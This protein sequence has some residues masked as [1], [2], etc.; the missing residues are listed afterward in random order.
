MKNDLSHMVLTVLLS[1]FFMGT[2]AAQESKLSVK[3]VVE[4]KSGPLA[5]VNVY[6]KG[7]TNG[8]I[9]NSKGVAS[10]NQVKAEDTIVFSFVGYIQQEVV[11]GNR[12]TLEIILQQDDLTLEDVVV[13][14][15]GTQKKVNLTGAV[16][17]IDINESFLSKPLT[18][19]SSALAGLNA[20]VQANQTSGQPGSDNASIYI[21]GIGTLNNNAPLILIDGIEGPIDAI[22][23]ADI[24]SISFLKD[25]AASA[26]YGVRAGNGVVL[27]TTKQAE[28]NK[29]SVTYN[30]SIALTQPVNLIDL[31]SNYADYMEFFNEAQA[32]SGILVP[33]YNQETIDL[34]RE[35]SKSPNE[36]NELGVP[37]YV[38]YPNTDW[39]K[40]LF[41]NSYIQSHNISMT[42]GGDKTRMLLSANYV[43]NPGLVENTGVKRY[44]IRANAEA[45]VTKWLT[46]GT[47]TYASQDDYEMGNFSSANSYLIQT[48]PGVYPRWNGQYGAPE[49]SE[50]NPMSNNL[51]EKLNNTDGTKRSSR[52]NTTLFSKINFMSNLSWEFR[53]N[54]NRRFDE[55]HTWPQRGGAV[56][57]STGTVAREPMALADMSVNTYNFTNYSYTLENLL[58]YNVTIA[59]NHEIS[60]LAGY[61]EFYYQS[62]WLSTEKKGLA[63]EYATIPSGATTLISTEGS[64]N[65]NASRSWFG[66]LN[67][68]YKSRYLFEGN[69][70]YDGTSKFHPKYRWGLFPSA[71]VAWRITEE[72]FMKWSRKYLDNLKIRVSY[73]Q[74]GN[75]AASGDYD[76]QSNYAFTAGYSLNNVEQIAINAAKIA[77]IN[78]GWERTNMFNVGLDLAAFGNRLN[79]Q[80]DVYNRV[81]KGILYVPTL[82]P[83]M[84][85]KTSASMNLAN[86]QN[87]GVELT[88]GWKDHIKDFHYSISAN[89]AFNKNRVL[90]YQGSLKQGWVTDKD[91][92]RKWVSNLSDVSNGSTR[93]VLEGHEMYVYYLMPTYKGSGKHFNADGTV[94]INGGPVDGMIRTEDDMK[95]LQAMMEAGYQFSPGNTVGK[96][97]IWYGD[98][99]YADT[100]QDKIY[101]N[102]YDNEFINKSTTPRVNYGIQV[103]LQYKGFDFYMNWAGSAGFMLYWAPNGGYNS[104]NLTHGFGINKEIAYNHYFYDPEDPNNARTNI[105]GKYERLTVGNAGTQ[106]NVASTRFLHK[107]DFLKLKNLVLGYTLPIKRV[108]NFRMPKIRVFLSGDNLLLIT[109]FP[110]QDPELGANPTYSSVRQFSAG[111][112]VTF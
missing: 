68:A 80:A 45:D 86:V 111:L 96:N 98:Y 18:N 88:V 47:K 78:M 99:I 74:L 77:N 31:V 7:T 107:G 79:F 71:A 4:D 97:N 94:D 39:Q 56:R 37:N 103:S 46:L 22:N 93:R 109:K 23:P 14:G 108:A 27:V 3:C 100:N 59:K 81:T 9:T 104:S 65:D 2:V 20:G 101:G 36:V 69:L 50:E 55:Q 63:D 75:S 26:I 66:R 89:M 28:R 5:G 49:A 44:N 72:N 51:L 87:R 105:H 102:S 53:F 90:K 58:R 10:L 85:N 64:K 25:A 73:G 40:V 8:T 19:V 92:N 35:K 21:R 70:R 16:S 41:Q 112:N 1:F 83:S 43:D 33:Q 15:Y 6:V 67:Y 110:G 32:N 91:G 106:N 76:Y 82:I 52:I 17:Q 60:A 11:V 13:V 24:E 84:G 48:N 38:A 34:W 61:Q 12:T 30:G 95:W 54:Y 57:F 62:S 29:V 42:A